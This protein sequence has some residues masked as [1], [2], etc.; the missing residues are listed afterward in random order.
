MKNEMPIRLFTSG[1]HNGFSFSNEDIASIAAKTA[2]ESP[3]RIPIVLG[4]P[5]NDLP[6]VGYIP[7]RAIG[8][9]KEGDKMSLGFERDQ[10]DLGDE[11]VEIARELG[12]NKISIRL[13]KGKIKHV[14]LVKKAAVAEN[15]EQDFEALTGDFM[16]VD[17]LEECNR[18]TLETVLDTIK[19]VFKNSKTD[20]D[21]KEK[22]E[23][24][25]NAE[26]SALKKDV[27]GIG[28]KV[29]RLEKLL[30]GREEERR[31]KALTA[32][33]AAAEYSHLTDE[34]K[35]KAVDFCAKLESED[36]VADYKSMLAAGNRKPEKPADGSVTLD[37]GKKGDEKSAEELIREQVS[38]V[39]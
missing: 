6:V 27:E 3:E 4:H 1:T 23:E 21:M 18:T 19:G 11:G 30:T 29:D 26:F 20:F 17:G 33:F 22:D 39:K 15:N 16:A 13:K 28:T 36:E 8:V 14:G 34:Q 31:R 38:A 35:A 25:Q 7:R 5:K 12:K 32:D 2:A 24:K 9:Y 10:A 37:F